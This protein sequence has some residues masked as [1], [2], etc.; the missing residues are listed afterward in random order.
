MDREQLE[1]QI[2]QYADGT[3]PATEVAALEELLKTDAE[4]RAML[5]TYRR[6]DLVLKNEWALPEMNWDR[7]ATHISAR[8]AQEDAAA[9]DANRSYRIAWPTW[10]RVA[11]AAMLLIAIGL[12]FLH[13][14]PRGQ[15]N[16]VQRPG[17]ATTN[18]TAVPMILVQGPQSERSAG[19]VV[20]IVTIQP[21]PLAQQSYDPVDDVVY[22]PPRVVIASGQSSRED[23][24]RLPF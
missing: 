2:S 3:L 11:I 24:S 7:L 17:D 6:L 13:L 8:V 22:R 5:D 18:P 21:S 10:G 12:A 9:N 16:I 1:F 19:K 15:T 23:T 4:A 20:E 14:L